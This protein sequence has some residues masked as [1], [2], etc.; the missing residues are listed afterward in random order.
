ML[1]SYVDDGFGGAGTWKIAMKL[2]KF[3]TDMGFTLETVVNS[4]KTEGPATSL[5]ILGLLYCSR[6]KVCRLD[7]AKVT[8]YAVRIS[9]L[10]AAGVASSKDLER[11]VGNLQF[12]SWVEPFGRPLL[13]F[14]AKKCS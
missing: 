2:I 12:A 5:V 8:K 4:A 6:S 1:G 7:P 14:I 11:I 9:K 3:I 10:L 13:S